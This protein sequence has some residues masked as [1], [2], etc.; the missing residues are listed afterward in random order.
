MLGF[1]CGRFDVSTKKNHL[2]RGTHHEWDKGGTEAKRGLQT[3]TTN[4][5]KSKGTL[6][7]QHTSHNYIQST[8]LYMQNDASMCT[9]RANKQHQ[10]CLCDEIHVFRV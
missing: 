8:K 10:F 7:V 3:D 5:T 4:K 1:A 2:E 6:T 9:N